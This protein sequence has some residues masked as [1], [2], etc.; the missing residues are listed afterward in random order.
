VTNSAL[1]PALQVYRKLGFV[2]VPVGASE[3]ARAD[4][5]MRLEL[6]A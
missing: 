2:D 3:Y 6:R 4:V 1:K 5:R